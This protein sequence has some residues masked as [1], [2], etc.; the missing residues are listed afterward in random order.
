MMITAAGYF[1]RNVSC[2]VEQF[3]KLS[4]NLKQ[5]VV[6]WNT[7]NDCTFNQIVFQIMATKHHNASIKQFAKSGLSCLILQ[8]QP[9]GQKRK[10]KICRILFY[11]LYG[12]LVMNFLLIFY[13]FNMLVASSLDIQNAWRKHT[14]KVNRYILVVEKLNLNFSKV[15]YPGYHLC[16]GKMISKKKKPAFVIC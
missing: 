12:R 8:S 10:E 15:V 5:S 9:N 1:M 2:I 16:G 3:S 6:L 14:Y 11:H 4:R 7:L 13:A